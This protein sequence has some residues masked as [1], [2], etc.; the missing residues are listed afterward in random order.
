MKKFEEL[1]LSTSKSFPSSNILWLVDSFNILT[2]LI[3][4]NDFLNSQLWKCYFTYHEIML[5]LSCLFS[6]SQCSSRVT[7]KDIM[8]I[9]NNYHSGWKYFKIV[10]FHL[11]KTRIPVRALIL[12]FIYLKLL[13]DFFFLSW[14]CWLQ[15]N[16]SCTVTWG[17]KGKESMERCLRLVLTSSFYYF[18]QG[19]LAE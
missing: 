5:R 19:R 10:F 2:V 7:T 15:G 12:H 6:I 13:H 16:S 11:C 17:H 9:N 3:N 14:K 18:L 1:H 4:L 8:S